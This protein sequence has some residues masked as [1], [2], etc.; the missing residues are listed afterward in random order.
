MF[1][2]IALL[3]LLLLLLHV[4]ADGVVFLFWCSCCLFVLF[5]VCPLALGFVLCFCVGVVFVFVCFVLVYVF[6]VWCLGVKF[7]FGVVFFVLCMQVLV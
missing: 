7:C 5:L 6:F 1:C 3:L 2:K 4:C